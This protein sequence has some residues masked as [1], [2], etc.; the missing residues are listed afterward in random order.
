MT[1]SHYTLDQIAICAL[2]S[3]LVGVQTKLQSATK[4]VET[5]CPKLVVF[6]FYWLQKEEIWLFLPHPLNAMRGVKGLLRD[7]WLSVFNFCERWKYEIKPVNCDWFACRDTWTLKSPNIRDFQLIFS[8]NSLNWRQ[9]LRGSHWTFKWTFLKGLKKLKGRL[10]KRSLASGWQ[11]RV[12]SHFQFFHRFY[13]NTG[14]GERFMA[15]TG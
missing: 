5:L 7:M 12:L 2:H 13:L 15:A 1:E 3:F 4:W 6:T 9:I 8:G 14:Y 10:F 11:N